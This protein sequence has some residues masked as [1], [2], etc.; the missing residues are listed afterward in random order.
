MSKQKTFSYW[1]WKTII[2]IL[3]F[4]TIWKA[5][6]NGYEEK[7]CRRAYRAA[8]GRPITL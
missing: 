7:R 2:G 1:Q 5:P 6:A 4:P 3:L 8:A